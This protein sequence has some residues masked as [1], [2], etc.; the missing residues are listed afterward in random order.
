MGV[1]SFRG[2]MMRTTALVSL[3]ALL[4]GCHVQT[5]LATP[6][7]SPPTGVSAPA[8]KAGD[9]VRIV[10]RDGTIAGLIVAEVAADAIV[11]PRGQRYAF[12]DITQLDRRTVASGKTAALLV[13]ITAGTFAAFIL[14]MLAAGWEL[15]P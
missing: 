1:A 13:G 2:P 10:M 3:A 4:C 6:G 11:G 5:R 12:A 8:V 14:M 15:D 7:E 9:E